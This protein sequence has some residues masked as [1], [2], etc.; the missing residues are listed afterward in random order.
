VPNGVLSPFSAIKTPEFVGFT[1]VDGHWTARPRRLFCRRFIVYCL[2]L[3][4]SENRFPL[5]GIML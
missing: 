4:F 2:R 5:F 3:I 1:P